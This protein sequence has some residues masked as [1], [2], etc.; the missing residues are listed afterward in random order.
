M[1]LIDVTHMGQIKNWWEEGHRGDNFIFMH[2]K[3]VKLIKLFEMIKYHKINFVPHKKLP[4]LVLNF[5]LIKPI[6]KF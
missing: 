4:T 6:Q 1:S 3:N 5:Q 2:H